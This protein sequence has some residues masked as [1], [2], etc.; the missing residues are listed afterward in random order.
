MI[1]I[2]ARWAD[3]ITGDSK[4]PDYGSATKLLIAIPLRKMFG[5]TDPSR[6]LL[7][8]VDTPFATE[9]ACPEHPMSV[10]YEHLEK[11]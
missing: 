1:L 8:F 9:P 5:H 11:S 3:D 2:A 7:A 10:L 4:D 6:T